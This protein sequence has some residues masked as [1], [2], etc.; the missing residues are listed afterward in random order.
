M[1]K[2]GTEGRITYYYRNPWPDELISVLETVLRQEGLI[3]DATH[4]GPLAHFFATVRHTT[5]E[6]K[7]G[8]LGDRKNLAR[9]DETRECGQ[10]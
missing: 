5:L 10:I 7:F 4:F 9:L 8:G 1:R 3:N 6:D 2:E